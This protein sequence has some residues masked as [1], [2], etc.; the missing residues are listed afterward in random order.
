MLQVGGAP[1]SLDGPM[2]RV[3]LPAVLVLAVLPLGCGDDPKPPRN[4]PEVTLTLSGP[5]DAATVRTRAE[6]ITGTVRPA[7][8]NVRVLGREVSVEGGRFSAD[9]PLE[10]GAN[11]IDVDASARA[12]GRTSRPCGSCTSCAWRCRTWAADADTA[13]EQLEGLGLKVKKRR[14]RRVLRLDPAGRPEGLPMQP[15]AGRAGPSGQRGRAVRRARLLSSAVLAGGDQRDPRRAAIAQDPEGDRA[16]DVRVAPVGG[17]VA[18]ARAAGGAARACRSSTSKSAGAT[19]RT[20]RGT[21]RRRRRALLAR[22]GDDT[23]GV[24]REEPAERRVSSAA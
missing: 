19:P 6:T 10:P 13:Q 14:R 18:P 20:G 8:A 3:A 16:G 17:D 9:V 22:A 1:A 12:A 24:A 11:L 21:R 23:L 15:R 7:A 4:E 5:A 2:R